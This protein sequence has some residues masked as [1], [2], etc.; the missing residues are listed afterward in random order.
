MT[1]ILR[2]RRTGYT[3]ARAQTVVA[4]LSAACRLSTDN[5]R[6]HSPGSC[7][8]GNAPSHVCLSASKTRL[9]MEEVVNSPPPLWGTAKARKSAPESVFWTS[10]KFSVATLCASERADEQL[11]PSMVR[12]LLCV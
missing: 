9:Q 11:L 2:R 10:P 8:I 3:A 6:P 4:W 12:Y 7:W 5:P 1:H